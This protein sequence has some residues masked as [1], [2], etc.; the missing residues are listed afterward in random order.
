M[1]LVVFGIRGHGGRVYACK[2]VLW[3]QR[4]IWYINLS[5]VYCAIICKTSKHMCVGK[6]IA[7]V[8]NNHIN[9]TNNKNGDMCQVIVQKS[10]LDIERIYVVYCHDVKTLSTRCVANALW[11]LCIICM[12]HHLNGYISS[13]R[14]RGAMRNFVSWAK[15]TKQAFN[16]NGKRKRVGYI[17]ERSGPMIERKYFMF[18]IYPKPM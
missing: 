11:H 3:E 7:C 2:Y 17:D 18:W 14:R 10:D 16:T 4:N 12:Y 8:F 5:L 15:K 1:L 9:N 13:H 6:W